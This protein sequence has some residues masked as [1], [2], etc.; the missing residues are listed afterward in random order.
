MPMIERSK[1]TIYLD[2]VDR[3]AIKAIRQTSGCGTDAAAIRLAI[4]TLARDIE[5]QAKRGGKARTT[6][7]ASPDQGSAD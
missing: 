5:R 2:Q 7:A 3:D 6:A 1:T 4:R